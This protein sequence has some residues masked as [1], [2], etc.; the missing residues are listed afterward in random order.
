MT[1]DGELRAPDA[2]WRRAIDLDVLRNRAAIDGFGQAD[3]PRFGAVR[4]ID[5]ERRLPVCDRAAD[6]I[7]DK[8]DQTHTLTGPVDAA[9]GVEIRI[10]IARRAAPIDAAI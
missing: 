1:V 7:A 4:T 5:D 10:D 9:L 3:A 2:A 8:T 6:L